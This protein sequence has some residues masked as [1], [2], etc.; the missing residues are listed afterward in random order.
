MLVWHAA[1]GAARLPKVGNGMGGQYTDPRSCRAA[2]S[3]RDGDALHA[4]RARTQAAEGTRQREAPLAFLAGPGSSRAGDIG[5]VAS[6]G[7][8]PAR[9]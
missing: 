7:P 8:C 3:R 4:V 5:L 6:L 9:A 2:E 1:S